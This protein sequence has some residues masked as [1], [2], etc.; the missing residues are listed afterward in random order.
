MA[1]RSFLYLL[2]A[3]LT[4]AGCF[5][6]WSCRQVGDLNWRCSTAIILRYSTQDDGISRL[7][8]YDNVRGIGFVILFL[9]VIIVCF[10][11]FPPRFIRHPKG[12]AIMSSAALVL[13]SAYHVIATLTVR[14]QDSEVFAALTNLTAAIVCIGAI[15]TFVAGAIDQHAARQDPA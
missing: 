4:V 2:G 8:I 5:F 15:L 11:F 3:S 9:T 13:V 14:L 6:P 7:E 10:A 1:L 12:V